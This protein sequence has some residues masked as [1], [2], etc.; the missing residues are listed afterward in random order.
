MV[1]WIRS[2][3]PLVWRETLQ[4]AQIE[5]RQAER[6]L[7]DQLADER[8][9]A[10]YYLQR[11]KDAADVIR[12][13][14]LVTFETGVRPDHMERLVTLE[15]EV[16]PAVAFM[17]LP[18]KRVTVGDAHQAGKCIEE[19]AWLRI[20]KGLRDDLRAAVQRGVGMLVK[21]GKPSE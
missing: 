11:F 6:R 19:V 14:S 8:K 13:P 15:V 2:W 12:W 9:R 7:Q 10:D 3:W 1:R 5:H 18:M 20:E 17:R 4:D 21:H 16:R